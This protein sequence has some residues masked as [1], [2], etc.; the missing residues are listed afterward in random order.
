[1]PGRARAHGA[2]AA[3]R[4]S[5][6]PLRMVA[7]VPMSPTRPFSCS[8][9]PPPPRVPPRP[10]WECRFLRQYV[11]GRSG[12]S[13]AGDDDGLQVK[14]TEKSHVLPSIAHKGIPRT[15]A[16]GHP[17]S[18]SEIDDVLPGQQP[19]QLAHRRQAAQAGVKHADWRIIHATDLL[20]F[21]LR[22]PPEACRRPS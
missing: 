9:P 10:R 1:M 18:I 12:H 20:L 13:A 16:V 14:G 2:S 7:W 5:Y 11:Q 19:L 22:H 8:G 17:R 15:T 6:A 21:P 3:I 4:R